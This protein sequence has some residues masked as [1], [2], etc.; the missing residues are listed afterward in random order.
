MLTGKD[1][2]RIARLRLKSAAFLIENGDYDLA[3]YIMAH[4]L[5]CALKAVVCKTLHLSSYPE[6]EKLHSHFKTHN[7]LIL[8]RLS[9][10]EDLFGPSG[11]NWQK[12]S[13]FTI[14][15]PGDWVGIRYEY[16]KFDHT[17]VRLLYECLDDKTKGREGI[18][19]L[20]CKHRRW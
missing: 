7:L 3:A 15:F 14:R 4:S 20:I 18:F 16:G 13:D 2:K 6:T 12:W 1:L 9:G 8:C 17:S 11:K 19:N 5:E 10:L